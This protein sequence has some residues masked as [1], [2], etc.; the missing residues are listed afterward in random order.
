M[1]DHRFIAALMGDDS[2]PM[3][4]P[5]RSLWVKDL[6]NPLRYWLLPLLR[7]TQSRL[8]RAGARLPARRRGRRLWPKAGGRHPVRRG[9]PWDRHTAHLPD[10]AGLDPSSG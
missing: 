5:A 1:S 10:G 8:R 4:E 3:S 9:V 7:V 2:L 6:Q